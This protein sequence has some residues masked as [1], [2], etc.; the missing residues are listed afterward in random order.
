MA[1]SV[2]SPTKGPIGGK[3]GTSAND[4]LE[5]TREG[6]TISG[7]AGDDQILG[8]GGD[9]WLYGGTGLDYLDGGDGNDHLYGGDDG[10]E[11]HGG[12]GND[13]LY[14]GDGYDQ[15]YGGAGDDHLYAGG[16][17]VHH[18]GVLN[19]GAGADVLEG[20]DGHDDVADYS[21]S[22]GAV[23]VN[24]GTSKGGGADAQGDTYYGI[25]FVTGSDFSDILIGSGDVNRLIGGA[26]NDQLFGMGEDDRLTGGVGADYLDGGAGY[27]NIEYLGSSAGVIVNLTT[28]TG[29]GGDAQGDTY[30][31]I[32]S[33]YGSKFDDTLIGNSDANTLDG[34]GGNDSLFGGGGED[35]LLVDG[36]QDTL[37]GGT[38]ADEFKFYVSTTTGD[39]P[40][41]IMDFSQAEGDTIHVAAIGKPPFSFIGTSAFS[42]AAWELRFEHA[43]GE[44]VISGD[45]DGDAQPDFEIHCIGTINFVESDFIP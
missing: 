14:G 19:G 17:G 45:T 36:G 11:L 22:P 40:D 23:Q 4:I 15:L 31:S 32:E 42:G 41:Y 44:T 9:D 37:T 38:G 10:D 28:S 27:D 12:N 18:A 2:L 7:L 5:G 34:K 20:G 13:W 35:V 26:G 6:N 33:V 30:F 39:L 21:D 3:V 43:A 29:A 25:E 1:G 8:Y 16:P 24:L